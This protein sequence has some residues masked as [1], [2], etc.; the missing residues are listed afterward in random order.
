MEFNCENKNFTYHYTNVV[1]VREYPNGERIE[2][3]HRE[4]RISSGKG[5]GTNEGLVSIHTFT[6]DE[7]LLHH[8]CFR[9]NPLPHG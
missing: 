2:V 7:C 4:L 3:P 5:S 9:S 1:W 6:S 8:V